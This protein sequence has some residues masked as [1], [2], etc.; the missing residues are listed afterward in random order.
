[1]DTTF[2][3]TIY[4]TGNA[5]N[6]VEMLC[7]LPGANASE[8][9]VIKAVYKAPDRVTVMCNDGLVR[10]CV[11][12]TARTV[13]NKPNL[14]IEQIYDKLAQKVGQEAVF[15]AASYNGRRWSSDQWFVGVIYESDLA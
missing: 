1:M 13:L 10:Q 3:D 2:A 15:V 12:K 6:K 8:A 14:T 7:A 9:V 5:S 4:T 11:L